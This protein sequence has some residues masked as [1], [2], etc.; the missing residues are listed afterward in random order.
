MLPVS[1]FDD[2]RNNCSYLPSNISYAGPGAGITV[3][4]LPFIC[5]FFIENNHVDY[6]KSVKV[7]IVFV[8]ITFF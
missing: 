1:F 3:S 8:D 4:C 5:D 7:A 2:T 6:A